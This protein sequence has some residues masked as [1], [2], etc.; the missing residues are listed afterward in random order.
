MKNNDLRVKHKMSN[1]RPYNIYYGI[2]RRCYNVKDIGY[3]RYGAKGIFMSKDWQTFEG[4]WKDMKETYFD[5]AEIDRIDN[6]KGYSKENCRWATELEQSQNRRCIK[7]YS[8]EGKEMSLSE[9]G[10]HLNISFSMLKDRIYTS[11]WSF[12]KA[13]KTPKKT[14]KNYFFD[15]ER[16]KYRVYKTVD[17]KK[18]TVARVNTE[19]EAKAIAKS[20]TT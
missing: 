17:K 14:N 11:K 7:K 12:E 2:R 9:W 15:K 20:F 8:Y 10:R 4:F 19:K 16:Q 18:I 6:T 1:T 5:G 13:I 3:A